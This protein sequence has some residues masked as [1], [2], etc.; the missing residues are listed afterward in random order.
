MSGTCW[1]QPA[2]CAESGAEGM[3]KVSRL[4]MASP[5][6]QEFF[7]DNL[8]ATLPRSWQEAL[9]GLSPPQLATLLLG[10][11]GEGEVVRYG[12]GG[13]RAGGLGTEPCSQS[14]LRASPRGF[15]G[16]KRGHPGHMGLFTEGSGPGYR[17]YRSVWPLTLLALKSTA[18]ALAFTRT[19]KFQTPSE[20]RENPSQ[21]SRLRAP[22]RKHVRPKKQHEIRRLGEVRQCLG[23]GWCLGAQGPKLVRSRDVGI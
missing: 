21:S 22:F 9:D 18:C 1:L 2:A 20:F 13:P 15:L 8:W 3:G 19:P 10:M 5:L 23:C 7:T 11:P 12:P 4:L 6:L 14:L 17:R 16:G